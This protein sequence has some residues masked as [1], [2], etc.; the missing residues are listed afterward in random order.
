MALVFLLVFHPPVEQS[1]NQQLPNKFYKRPEIECSKKSEECSVVKMINKTTLFKIDQSVSCKLLGQK[2]ICD[3]DNGKCERSTL[4]KLI[5]SVGFI[6]GVV[7]IGLCRFRFLLFL[8]TFLQFIEQQPG[9]DA[10][11]GITGQR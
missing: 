9:A 3:E 10:A 4:L 2:A 11:T 5:V 8:N 7:F 6:W 1:P